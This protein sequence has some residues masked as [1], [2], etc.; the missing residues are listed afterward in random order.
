MRH[1]L[2]FQ[3]AVSNAYSIIWNAFQTAAPARTASLFP[4][5]R[6]VTL[7]LRMPLSAPPRPFVVFHSHIKAVGIMKGSRFS[8]YRL[9]QFLRPPLLAVRLVKN[10][11]GL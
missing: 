3:P 1:R 10:Q 4:S 6:S 7:S 11:A 5:Q 2:Y 9:V 8:S